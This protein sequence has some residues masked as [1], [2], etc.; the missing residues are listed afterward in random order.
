M[1]DSYEIYAIVPGTQEHHTR[2]A[3]KLYIYSTKTLQTTAADSWQLKTRKIALLAEELNRGAILGNDIHSLEALCM[4]YGGVIQDI[5]TG[6]VLTINRNG[7]A[8]EQWTAT[9]QPFHYE[10]LTMV[11]GLANV[12][13][14]QVR[15]EYRSNGNHSM[16]YVKHLT[17][18][19]EVIGLLGR[20]TYI[21]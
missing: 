2:I 13:A 18:T 3:A 8:L 11:S 1:S 15:T 7:Y 16:H 17:E 19:P 12:G 9:S 21:P 10:S 4:K 6:E 5:R 20:I 14:F